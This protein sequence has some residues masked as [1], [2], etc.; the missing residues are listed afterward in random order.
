MPA[1]SAGLRHARRRKG[2]VLAGSITLIG[3]MGAGKTA[4]GAELARRLGRP[5]ADS[6][7]EIEAAAAMT[8]PEIFARDGE[9]FFRDREAQVIARLLGA[10]PGVL[11]TGG[12]AWLHPANRAVIREGGVA[13]WLDA[14]TETLWQRLR[15]RSGRPLLATDD[16]RA[17]LDALLA[18][19]RP[20]YA[21]A[22]LRVEIGPQ[23]GIVS[24][25]EAVIRAI[26]RHRPE[27]LE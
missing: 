10:A 23:D 25:T 17:T 18:Q 12:G 24:T 22:D 6:D 4:I 21:R 3:M 26:T 27:I 7:A 13:V 14:D 8:I 20:V 1:Q 16:P 15:G 19:R 5:F 2:A 11:A 9:G